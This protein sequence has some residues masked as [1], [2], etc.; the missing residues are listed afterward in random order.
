MQALIE[1]THAAVPRSHGR[2]IL[3]S[4]DSGDEFSFHH[5]IEVCKL[6]D[7]GDEPSTT[8]EPCYSAEFEQALKETLSEVESSTAYQH[9]AGDIV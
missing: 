2:P 9:F 8:E 3:E 1:T 6:V 4:Y 5:W 7:A